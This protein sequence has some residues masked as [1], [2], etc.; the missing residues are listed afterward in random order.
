VAASA[1]G[2]AEE[3]ITL[4]VDCAPCRGECS[5]LSEYVADLADELAKKAGLP[6]VRL[7]PQ[8]HPMGYGKWEGYLTAR[9][10][11]SPPA[12]GRWWIAVEGSKFKQVVI[13]ALE[14]LAQ[15]IVRP[16]GR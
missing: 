14:P 13:A 10:R 1:A 4:Y 3:G 6:D 12:A 16:I 5:D 11:E 2:S 7:A 8:E 9:V 15:E